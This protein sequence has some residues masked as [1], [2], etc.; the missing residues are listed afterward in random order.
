MPVKKSTTKRTTTIRELR[1][2]AKAAGVRGWMNMEEA[3]LKAAIAAA[4]DEDEAPARPAKRTAAKKAAATKTAA[5]KAPAKK[6]AAKAAPA[7]KR[8]ADAEGDNPFKPGSNMA[9]ITDA[10]IRGGKRSVMVKSLLKKIELKPSASTEN[11]DEEAEM[12]HRILIVAQHL[13][14]DHGFEV[15]RDGRGPDAKIVVTPPA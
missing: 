10:L 1:R 9:I 15:D 4:G 3:E 11:F 5:K 8:A 13:R 2:Q 7:N 6:A 12:D 14:R